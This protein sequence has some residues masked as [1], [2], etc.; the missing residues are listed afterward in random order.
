MDASGSCGSVLIYLY[1]ALSTIVRIFND[2]I[3]LCS[4]LWLVPCKEKKSIFWND[5]SGFDSSGIVCRYGMELWGSVS[6]GASAN[7]SSALRG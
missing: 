2:H 6:E 4:I 1:N 7:A 3:S 5:I